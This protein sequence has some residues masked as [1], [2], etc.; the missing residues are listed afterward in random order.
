[1]GERCRAEYEGL[2]VV[3]YTAVPQRNGAPLRA[4]TV[5][6]AI[7]DL[8]PIANGSDKVELEYSGERLSFAVYW[9]TV[10]DVHAAMVWHPRAVWGR[11]RLEQAR[12]LL[13]PIIKGRA[14]SCGGSA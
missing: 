11:A 7:G 3:Q 5:R 9:K 10:R 1:M 8:P 6:D 13:A 12:M 4:I 2:R 14:I